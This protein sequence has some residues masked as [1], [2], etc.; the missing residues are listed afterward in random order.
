M[1]IKT[2][3]NRLNI[4]IYEEELSNKLKIYIV[5]NENKN[6]IYVT[7]NTKY[8]S[9]IN[10]F[11]PIGEE[12]FIKVPDGVAHF[13]EHKLF[14]QEDGIRFRVIQIAWQLARRIV[15]LLEI[16][17]TV[18]QWDTIGLIKFWSQVTIVFD[19]NVDVIAKVW[20]I[21]VDG[22]TIIAKAKNTAKE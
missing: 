22:E 1:M 5:K 21:V 11:V 10:E 3:L 18:E 19:K 9:N 8:G 12:K 4:D 20:D 14:E 17:D 16:N 13:L 2:K 15:P 7:F 6:G